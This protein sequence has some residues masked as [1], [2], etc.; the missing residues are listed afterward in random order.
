M[1]I[2]LMYN[3]LNGEGCTENEIK[4]VK[5]NRDETIPYRNIFMIKL[6]QV[7]Q[8]ASNHNQDRHS[9]W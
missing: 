8:P 2:K 1:N 3:R 7:V 5:I 4:V 6:Y 9:G